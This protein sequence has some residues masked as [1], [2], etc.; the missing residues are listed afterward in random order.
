MYDLILFIIILIILILFYIINIILK[1]NIEKYGIYCGRYNLKPKT[2]EALCKK[3]NNCSWNTYNDTSSGTKNNWCSDKPLNYTAAT[4]TTVYEAEEEEEEE[5]A[6]V[7]TS[8]TSST[9]TSTVASAAV[10]SSR[11]S[12]NY[13]NIP[14]SVNNFFGN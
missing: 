14:I 9:S 5:A 8:T 6:A 11:S 7:V 13:K 2:A 3:D 1:K 12:T 4:T 10:A